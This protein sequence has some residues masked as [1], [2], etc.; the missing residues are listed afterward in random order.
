MPLKSGPGLVYYAVGMLKSGQVL[1]VDG[2]TDDHWLRVEYPKGSKGFVKATDASTEDD[3]KAIRLTKPATIWAVNISGGERANWRY[4]LEDE[5]AVGA[6]FPVVETLKTPDG[7]V[8]GYLVPAPA[9]ARAFVKEDSVRQATTEESSTA[10]ATLGAATPTTPPAPTPT[11]TPE[12]TIAA[13]PAS[14]DTPAATT[15]PPAVT[16]PVTTAPVAAAPVHDADGDPDGGSTRRIQAGRT[17][18]RHGRAAPID[19]PAGPIR[20]ECGARFGDR[21]VRASRGVHPV[22]GRRQADS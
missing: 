2:R 10:A 17:P 5:Q 18:D 19:L 16:D 6:R 22:A 21:R 20:Q 8:Y 15:Q 11:P 4:L 14:N 12:K 13:K 3:G 9:E 7:K 1:R